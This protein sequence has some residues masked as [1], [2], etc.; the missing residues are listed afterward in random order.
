M[1]DNSIE[2]QVELQLTTTSRTFNLRK[3]KSEARQ[4]PLQF[5]CPPFELFHVELSC[6]KLARMSRLG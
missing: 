4:G 5:I 6:G 1:Q 3:L 2:G